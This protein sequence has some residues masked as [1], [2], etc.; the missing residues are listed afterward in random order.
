MKVEQSI[1]INLP[2]EEVF[3]YISDL[4]NLVDWCSV[5]IAVRNL[6]P[7]AF[8]VGATM[9]ATIRFLGRWLDMTFEV[10]ER[11]PDRCLT[12]KSI[13]G[14][15]PCLFCYRFEP[16]QC[17]GTTLIQESTIESVESI[18]DLAVPVI[19]RSINR[20]LEYDLQTLKDLLEARASACE[21][22]WQ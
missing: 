16:N 22:A 7:K 6:S 3:S 20:Q 2:A 17:G 14:I 13:A 19:M 18:I 4:E 15:S 21:A 10:I 1:V 9:K 5:I 8:E 11:E 12:L